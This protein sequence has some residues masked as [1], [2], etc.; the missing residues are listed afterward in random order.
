VIVASGSLL[1]TSGVMVRVK[2]DPVTIGRP[3]SRI[4]TVGAIER[5]VKLRLKVAVLPERRKGH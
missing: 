2:R 3:P 5:T 4:S 1:R